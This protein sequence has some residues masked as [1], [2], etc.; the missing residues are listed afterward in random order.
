L[1]LLLLGIWAH[2]RGLHGIVLLLRVGVAMIGDRLL[3]VGIHTE[4]R[5]TKAH[6]GRDLVLLHQRSWSGCRGRL[7]SGGD[8]TGDGC[9]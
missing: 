1:L 6:G 7:G 2:G 3:L 9:G 5:L 4:R 8:T